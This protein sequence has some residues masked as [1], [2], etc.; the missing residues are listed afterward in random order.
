MKFG[1]IELD[2]LFGGIQLVNVPAKRL[3][4]DLATA[5]V[6]CNNNL[7]GATFSPIWYV[8]KQLVNG[9]NH[10]LVCEE[11]RTTREAKPSIVLLTINIPVG[12]I[13]GKDAKIVSIVESSDV[14]KSLSDMFTEC[15]GHLVGC[16]YKLVTYVG[17]Q[18]VKGINH[19]FIAEAKRVIP[20]SKPFPVMVCVNEFQGVHMLVSIEVISDESTYSN[21]PLGE[22]P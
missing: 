18:I 21:G 14:S 2:G 11:I 13:G 7:L 6:E 16:S 8:G 10:I 19:Y 9:M 5:F 12:S 22:W 17:K 4:Q 3:P 20:N 1:G 15:T